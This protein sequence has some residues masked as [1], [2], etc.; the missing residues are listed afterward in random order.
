M[1]KNILNIFVTLVFCLVI[2][3][4]PKVINI[5]PFILSKSPHI[6][7]LEHSDHNMCSELK[8]EYNHNDEEHSHI[9]WKC[10][11]TLMKYRLIK[12]ARDPQSKMHNQEIH[13][14]LSKIVLKLADNPEVSLMRENR[15]L[16]NRQ[17]RQ[18]LALGY[19]VETT[20]QVKIDKYFLCRKI[21][22]EKHKVIPPYG[23][24]EYEKYP[25]QSYN[26]SF[27]VNDM[28]DKE[29]VK[30]REAKKKYPTC[31]KYNLYSVDFE[32][33]SKAQDNARA[34]FKKVPKQKFQKEADEKVICQKKAYLRFPTRFLK[35][36]LEMKKELER[37]K[38][39][40]D[41]Y[42][43]HNFASLGIDVSLFHAGNEDVDKEIEEEIKKT[44]A[45]DREINSKAGLYN[46]FELTKLRQKFIF[47]CLNEADHKI[48]KY[49]DILRFSCLELEKFEALGD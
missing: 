9:Y 46:K 8:L 24:K 1:Q 3:C 6:Q 41:F 16:S 19:D 12:G 31:V 45:Q 22:M 30:Y 40:S 4:A 21:L 28:L 17:H 14:V 47:N 38:S 18:C 29:I 33:C 35:E 2:T 10:R 7:T 48:E 25:N 37:L 36:N 34:C 49:V 13:G 43:Q 44:E 39:N 42:N 32:N 27:I 23:N 15:K 20:D 5:S 11:Q 26:L